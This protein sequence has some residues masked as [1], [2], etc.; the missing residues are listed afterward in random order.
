MAQSVMHISRTMYVGSAHS[1]SAVDMR[2]LAFVLYQTCR[3]ERSPYDLR[4]CG[5]QPH[6]QPLLELLQLPDEALQAVRFAAATGALTTQRGG[7][8]DA[9]PELKE[10]EQ[11][12]AK[13][14]PHDAT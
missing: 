14:Y 4:V 8:I 7:A 5:V 12:V 11:L 1:V 3:C 10:I 6:S 13:T 9:Q 2:I